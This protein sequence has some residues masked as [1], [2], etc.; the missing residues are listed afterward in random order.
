MFSRSLASLRVILSIAAL[1]TAGVVL[2]PPAAARAAGDRGTAG[3]DEV[4]DQAEIADKASP[5]RTGVWLPGRLSSARDRDWFR[6]RLD[7]PSSV[8]ITLGDVATDHRLTVVD[9]S[10][11]RWGLSDRPGTTFEELQLRLPAGR[12]FV[13]VSAAPA[14]GVTD[15]GYRLMIRPL[16]DR[17]LVLD[18]HAATADGLYAINGQLLNNTGSWRRHPRITARFYGAAGEFLGASTALAAQSYLGPRQ[19]GHFRIVA[20]RPEG[21]VRYTLAVRATRVAPPAQ[22]ELVLRPDRPYPVDSGRLRYVGR[23]SGAA[24]GV[25]VHVVR[26]NRIGAFVD[27]G[28]AVLPRLRPGEP[29]RYE[30]ELPNYPYVRGERLTYSLG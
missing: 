17:T 9:A 4:P 29:G 11:R 25:H 1:V 19:R 26:Y 18:S 15:Q 8:V 27:S 13:E 28:H 10:G 12:Y 16:P 24:V 22:P 6:F 23:I 5:A 3:R 20:D 21:T 30:I 2:I 14:A 7:R